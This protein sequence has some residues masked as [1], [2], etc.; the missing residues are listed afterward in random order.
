MTQ[1]RLDSELAA[2]HQDSAAAPD[3]PFWYR[4]AALYTLN[5][6]AFLASTPDA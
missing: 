1:P 2:V 5:V 3:D 6:K 4:D